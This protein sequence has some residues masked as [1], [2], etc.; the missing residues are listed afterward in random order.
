VE[1]KQL[2]IRFWLAKSIVGNNVRSNV[3]HRLNRELQR[4]FNEALLANVGG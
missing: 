4:V 3:E 1:V 2:M